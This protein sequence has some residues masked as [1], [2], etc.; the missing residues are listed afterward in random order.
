MATALV[1]GASGG[2]GEALARLL[3]RDRHPVILV[4]AGGI[5]PSQPCRAPVPQQLARLARRAEAA[6]VGRLDGVGDRAPRRR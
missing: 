4:A 2:I 3:S 5:G 1:T 6:Q